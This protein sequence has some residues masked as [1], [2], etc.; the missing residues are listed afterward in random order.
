[1]ATYR[2]KKFFMY[3]EEVEIETDSVTDAKNKAKEVDGERNH[4]D[5]LYDCEVI[6]V[7]E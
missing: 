4:D 7:V 6:S 1:M 3:T 5:H 2:V